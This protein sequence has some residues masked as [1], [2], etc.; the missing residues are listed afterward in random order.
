MKEKIRKL[1]AY[2]RHHS[3]EPLPLDRLGAEAGLSPFHLQRLFKAEVGLTPRQYAEACRLEAFKHRLRASQEKTKAKT[4]IPPTVTAALYES[5]FGS[6]SR[7]YERVPGRL[8]M[9]PREYRAGGRAVGITAVTV[10]TPLGL[11]LLAATDRG[12]CFVQFGPSRAALLAGLR[13]EYAAARIEVLKPPYPESLHRWIEALSDYLK[14]GRQPLDLPIDI[15]ATAF[16]FRVWAHLQSIPPGTVQSYAEVARRLGKPSAAR[17]VAGAC[18]AN[19]LALV[20]PCHR[21]IRGDGTLGGFRWG[22]ARKQS[23]LNLERHAA[24]SPK[25]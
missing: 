12:L 22:L 11:L 18:A 9:T 20:I 14:G 2:I 10:S 3:D 16:Q 17:A 21:V 13:A 5:G 15:R 1:C 8:G 25:L 24:Q 19:R 4:K 6:S 7:L 23:L